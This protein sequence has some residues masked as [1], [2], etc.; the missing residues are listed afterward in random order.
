MMVKDIILE[1][2]MCVC[3]CVCACVCFVKEIILGNILIDIL[4]FRQQE[5]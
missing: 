2:G 1:S 5:S 4:P 3:L